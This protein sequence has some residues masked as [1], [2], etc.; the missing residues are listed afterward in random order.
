[1]ADSSLADQQ[2][3]RSRLVLYQ[4]SL[5]LA[6]VAIN[7]RAIQVALANFGSTS[8]VPIRWVIQGLLL[9]ACAALRGNKI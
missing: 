8:S 1:M 3:A 7:H 6:L 9:V 2:K 5:G 4:V